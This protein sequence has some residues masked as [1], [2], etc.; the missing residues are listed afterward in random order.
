MA[1]TGGTAVL[2]KSTSKAGF[3]I[4]LYVYYKT[5]QNTL[6]NSS[7]VFTGMYVVTPGTKYDIG[8]WRDNY[9]SYVGTTELTF[10]GAIPN[11]YGTKWIVENKSFTVRHNDDGTG[12]A[13]IYWK[14]GV[15]STWGGYVQPSGSFNITLPTI[16]RYP[17]APSACIAKCGND[18]SS[19]FPGDTINISW[20][21][22]S[23][24]ITDYKLQ[25]A[26]K[27][28]NDSNWGAWIDWATVTGTSK[29]DSSSRMSGTQIKYRVC[30]RN[31]TLASSYK[32]SN[33]LTIRGGVW[34]NVNGSWKIGTVYVK[35]SG[36]WKRAKDVKIQKNGIWKS[37]I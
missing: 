23:G 14:W 27:N 32:E 12:T 7:D 36:V 31:G 37:S 24:T 3:D 22:A 9:G 26:I 17:S 16:N 28:P 5:A 18:S 6:T 25:Y 35:S 19:Y 29:S 1:M 30:A 15:N 4:S 13:T 20:S 2:V 21:G 34:I 33:V 8:P 10:D 11:C